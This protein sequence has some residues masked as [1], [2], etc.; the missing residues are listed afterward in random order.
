MF[1]AIRPRGLFRV[2]EGGPRAI[3]VVNNSNTTANTP[4]HKSRQ[5]EVG[6]G[7]ILQKSPVGQQGETYGGESAQPRKRLSGLMKGAEW[8]RPAPCRFC[9]FCYFALFWVSGAPLFVLH[10]K[11][12]GTGEDQSS[13][14]HSYASLLGFPK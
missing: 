3:G 4:T 7:V 8:R 5:E 6:R 1:G 13:V 9:L 2:M 14:R 10:Y 11:G 12:L